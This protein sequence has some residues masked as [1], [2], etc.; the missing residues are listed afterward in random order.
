MFGYQES[1]QKE[2]KM[3]WRLICFGYIVIGYQESEKTKQTKK[4]HTII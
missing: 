4:I 2:K 3:N 1:S